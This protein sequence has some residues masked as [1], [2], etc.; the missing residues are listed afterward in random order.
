MFFLLTGCCLPKVLSTHGGEVLE[1]EE[2]L[3]GRGARPGGSQQ[4]GTSRQPGRASCLLCSPAPLPGFRRGLIRTFLWAQ[5]RIQPF[6]LPAERRCDGQQACR[7][8]QPQGRWD[9]GRGLLQAFWCGEA[10]H[11]GRCLM[12]P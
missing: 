11:G 2:T 8:Q 4:C 3:A 10:T 1:E 7:R 9:L 5:H 12:A 6:P